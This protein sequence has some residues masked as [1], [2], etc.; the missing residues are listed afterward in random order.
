MKPKRGSGPA[1]RVVSC[2]D[3]RAEA[4][5]VVDTIFDMLNNED[6]DA[7][8]SVAIYTEPTLNLVT[9]KKRAS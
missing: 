4:N 9:W 1:P 7:D 2:L 5:F 6:I 3:E 8:K